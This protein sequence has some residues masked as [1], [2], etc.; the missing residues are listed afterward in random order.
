M[1][2]TLILF[3]IPD[4]AQLARDLLRSAAGQ[5]AEL[6]RLFALEARQ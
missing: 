1:Y 4:D 2:F 5:V 3:S 6:T